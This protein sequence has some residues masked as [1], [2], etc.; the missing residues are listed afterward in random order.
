[1]AESGGVVV[2][3]LCDEFLRVVRDAGS[4]LDVV[5]GALA[6]LR[7]EILLRGIPD[8]DDDGGVGG[9]GEGG[10]GAGTAGGEGNKNKGSSSQRG[11]VWLALLGVE[12]VDADRY[13]ALVR[14]GE[15][16]CYRKIR[17]DSFRTFPSDE[18]FQRSVSEPEIIRVLNSFVQ[19]HG[20][21][22]T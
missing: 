22:F 8:G 21:A 10:T 5:G 1:M 15:S 19:E 13:A 18:Q 20:P 4:P 14:R 12:S 2:G 9:G 7:R 3:V 6:A 17:N 16:S 11:R